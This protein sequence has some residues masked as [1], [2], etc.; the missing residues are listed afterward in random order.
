MDKFVEDKLEEFKKLHEEQLLLYGVDSLTVGESY[1]RFLGTSSGHINGL[2]FGP[3]APKAMKGTSS[4]EDNAYFAEQMTQQFDQLEKAAHTRETHLTT[5]IQGLQ[6]D[7]VT[8]TQEMEK[9]TQEM[10]KMK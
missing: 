2:G 9:M 1:I 6:Q 3:R 4:Y 10:K 5:Q 8:M 7:K